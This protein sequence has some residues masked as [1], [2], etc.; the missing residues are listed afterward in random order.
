MYTPAPDNTQKISDSIII[1]VKKINLDPK[2]NQYKKTEWYNRI[3]EE[4]KLFRIFMHL[5]T[6]SYLEKWYLK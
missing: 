6:K 4:Q 1:F 5:S 3:D 2:R